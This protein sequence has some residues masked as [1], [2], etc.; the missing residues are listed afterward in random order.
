M[1]AP[2]AAAVLKIVSQHVVNLR[3]LVRATRTCT[4]TS[5]SVRTSSRHAATAAVP[6]SHAAL[7]LLVAT[8]METRT[9]TVVETGMAAMQM[10]AAVL[11]LLVQTVKVA[12]TVMVVATA[13]MQTQA[14]VLQL[15]VATAMV[16]ATAAMQTQA[17]VLQLL[18]ATVAEATLAAKAAT[19]ATTIAAILPS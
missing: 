4:R 2:R 1:D 5:A 15:L 9:A 19:A 8:G 3:L 18:V 16:V 10:Q 13:A 6:H 14:A 7:Q 17:A 12:A 11:Q